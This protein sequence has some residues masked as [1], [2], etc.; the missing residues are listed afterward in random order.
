MSPLRA[1][2][3]RILTALHGAL[4]RWLAKADQ[5][6]PIVKGK[7]RA[8]TRRTGRKR[9]E[10]HTADTIER[11]R[12]SW[13]DCDPDTIHAAL[14]RD[15]DEEEAEAWRRAHFRINGHPLP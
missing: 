9:A 4:G 15:P 3:V 14:P 5:P 13:F 6:A 8:R 11:K 2:V 12:T 7:P 1:T 10:R